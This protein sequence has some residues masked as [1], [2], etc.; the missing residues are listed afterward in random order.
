[1]NA[2]RTESGR[3]IGQNCLRGSTLRPAFPLK[4]RLPGY[5]LQIL[6]MV[7]FSFFL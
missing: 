3:P 1:M 2:L 7:I 4:G 5:A 6:H